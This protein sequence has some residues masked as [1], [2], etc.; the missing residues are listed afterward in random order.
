[1]NVLNY[2]NE[3]LWHENIRLCQR[4]NYVSKKFININSL[5]GTQLYKWYI[6]N[7]NEIYYLH[8]YNYTYI[9]K[10]DF[11]PAID[12]P[13]YYIDICNFCDIK[14]CVHFLYYYNSVYY[15]IL[16]L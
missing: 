14:I 11:I 5:Y 10:N 2:Q 16:S 12:S 6:N 13:D 15:F 9:S 1:M 7:E 4:L 8:L 3:Y